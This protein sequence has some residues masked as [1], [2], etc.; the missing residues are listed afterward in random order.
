MPTRKAFEPHFERAPDLAGFER[1]EEKDL[2]AQPY[3]GRA[4]L[5]KVKRSFANLMYWH[6]PVVIIDEAHNA[7][8]ALSYETFAR[9]RPAALIEMTATP[10]RKGAHRSNVLYHVSAEAL[11]AEQMIKLPI[12]L[13]AHPNWQEAVRDALLTRKR[14]AA[15]AVNEADY[16][17]PILLLQAEDKA[18]EVTVE[19]AARPPD[20]AGACGGG[21]HRRGDGHPARSWT[22]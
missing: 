19:K 20:R 14:L 10:V 21:E 12:V 3:L 1:V 4:D 7:R 9:L 5:G 13:Q 15:E 2:A 11:K 17:R 6:R 8:G 22:A 18:G 16:L